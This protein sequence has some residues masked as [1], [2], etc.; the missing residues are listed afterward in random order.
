[1]ARSADNHENKKKELLKV[2]EKLFLDKGYE[3]TSID[4]ILKES[5]ISKGGFYHYFKSK[6]EVL[7][8]SINNIIEESIE[9]L[10]PTV[11]DN[12]LDALEKFKL[13][14]RKKSEFQSTKIEYATLLAS[15]LQSDVAQYKYSLAMSQK[16]VEPFAKIIDQGAKEGVFHV[17]YPHETADILIRTVT[18]V[19]QSTSYEEYLH[20][21]RKHRQYLL[22]LRNLIARTLGISPEEFSLYDE[23][24]EK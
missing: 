10:M 4:D 6:D 1:M 12:R 15:I 18:S 21:E 17:D 13:F 16:M 24:A 5:G 2:A 7:S 11:E 8:E 9:Y 23:E 14:M 3:Q 19:V 22:S 20:D